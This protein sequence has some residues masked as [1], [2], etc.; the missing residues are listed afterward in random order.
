[1]AERPDLDYAVPILDRELAGKAVIGV[2]VRKPVVLRVA[3]PGTPEALLTGARIESVR[4]RGHFVL[5][6]LRQPAT[7]DIAVAPMLA[8]RFALA[9]LH[10]K[11]P[12][13]LAIGLGLDDG[14][15]LRYRDDVQMG[16]FYLIERG[17]FAKVPGLA[18]IG[19]D[20]LNPAAFTLA[21]FLALARKRRD[22]VKIFLMDKGALDA[23]GNAYSDEVLWEAQIHPKRFVRSLTDEDLGRLHAAIPKVLGHAAEVIAERKPPIDEKLRDFL[24]VRGRAG[25]PCHRCGTKL[26]TARVRADD[27]VF[28]PKCQVDERG[29]AIVDWRKI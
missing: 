18:S 24:H 9:A 21:R 16:K 7:I 3:V 20:V 25:Q 28:C 26:R 14:R 23:M 19:V 6:E 13:D 8:G 15:E 2:L 27:A 1:M 11:K 4:R 10:D 29:T 12:G 17:A 5:F 22:Q